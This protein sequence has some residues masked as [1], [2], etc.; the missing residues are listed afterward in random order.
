MDSAADPYR[1]IATPTRGALVAVYGEMLGRGRSSMR[2]CCFTITNPTRLAAY[3]PARVLA[4]AKLPSSALPLGRRPQISL[5]AT[6][7]FQHHE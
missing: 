3:S 1:V 5:C 6:T 7:P 2:Y 4:A